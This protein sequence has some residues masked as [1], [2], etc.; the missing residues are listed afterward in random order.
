[1]LKYGQKINSK[2]MYNYLRGSVKLNKTNT[3]FPYYKVLIMAPQII[4]LSGKN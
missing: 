3:Y 1:M 4:N 2:Y